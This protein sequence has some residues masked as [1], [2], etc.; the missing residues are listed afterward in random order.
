[1][2]EVPALVDHQ[3]DNRPEVVD[4]AELDAGESVPLEEISDVGDSERL[5]GL[6]AHELAGG[7]GPRAEL[8]RVEVVPEQAY[9]S[10]AID[11][12]DLHHVKTMGSGFEDRG[13][14]GLI[15]TRAQPSG[16]PRAVSGKPIE[17]S[18]RGVDGP[19]RCRLAGIRLGH[20]GFEAGDRWILA[21][22]VEDR[23]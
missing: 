8:R 5:D 9:L 16:R 22:V 19:D 15:V 23:A 17:R 7:V 1:M 18:V 20:V 2:A 10:H 3:I 21:E 4:E 6:V 12:S 13:K 14:R 11:P